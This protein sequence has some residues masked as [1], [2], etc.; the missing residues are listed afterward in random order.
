MNRF[1]NFDFMITAKYISG[2]YL[3]GQLAIVGMTFQMVEPNSPEVQELQQMVDQLQE[4]ATNYPSLYMDDYKQAKLQLKQLKQLAGDSGS[5]W[6]VVFYF[7]G[8]SLAW[9]IACEFLIV[10]FKIH[11]SLETLPNRIGVPTDDSNSSP[12][13]APESSEA[14]GKKDKWASLADD[15]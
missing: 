12:D 14:S 4:K 5:M 6:D 1:L 15:D 2:L 3:I 10:L 7:L 11:E 13:D 8:L 9:R